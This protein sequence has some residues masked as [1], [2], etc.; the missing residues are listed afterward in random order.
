MTTN[1]ALKPG[2]LSQL[3]HSAG[4]FADASI[5]GPEIGTLV[6]I[7]D[8]A[9]N[10]PNRK[11]I[12]KQDP[13]CAA[14]LGKEAHKT[15]TDIRGG[16]TPRWDQELRFKVHD[17]PDYYQLKVSIFN[18][19]KKTDLIGE[20]WVDLKDI[21]K[22]GGGQN[23]RW[24][25][26]GC[27]GKYAGEIRIEL[28]YYDN[29]PKP[30]T[31]VRSGDLDVSPI[32]ADPT[33]GSA[34]RR[35]PVKRRPLP[36]DPVTG[37]IPSHVNP[38]PPLRTAPSTSH[39]AIPPQMQ[40]AVAQPHRVGP[41][42]QPS[43]RAE[44][45]QA[46]ALAQKQKVIRLQQQQQE[47]LERNQA[48]HQ[49]FQQ[50]LAKKEAAAAAATAAAVAAV[51]S[52]SPPSNQGYTR[53]QYGIPV[54]SDNPQVAEAPQEARRPNDSHGNIVDP[55]YP[56]HHDSFMGNYHEE[57]APHMPTQAYGQQQM[58]LDGKQSYG[59][60]QQMDDAP[61]P[62]PAHRSR[63]GSGTLQSQEASYRNVY[64]TVQPAKPNGMR[65][66]VLR[67]QAHRNPVV[68]H[69]SPEHGPFAQP[70]YHGAPHQQ[71]L[72]HRLSMQPTVEDV[73][74][75][76]NAASQ[77]IIRKSVGRPSQLGNSDPGHEPETAGQYQQNSVQVSD[78]SHQHHGGPKKNQ[79][80][81]HQLSQA[82]AHQYQP[83]PPAHSSASQ[84]SGH[85]SQ[86]LEQ[87]SHHRQVSRHDSSPD[88]NYQ[89]PPP[90]APQHQTMHSQHHPQ[91]HPVSQM[92]QP[93][94]PPLSTSLS[95]NN[96]GSQ[97]NDC[98]NHQIS[99]KFGHTVTQSPI[100]GEG[101]VSSPS[102]YGTSP[103][104]NSSPINESSDMAMTLV[105]RPVQD[106]LPGPSIPASLIPGVDP[107]IAQEISDLAHEKRQR[108]RGFSYPTSIKTFSYQPS[109]GQYQ[110]QPQ[111][112]LP[113]PQYQ[114]SN[115]RQSQ[116]QFQAHSQ[117]GRSMTNTEIVP[118]G[119]NGRGPSPRPYDPKDANPSTYLRHS[120]S[121]R[122]HT[123]Q[124]PSPDPYYAS[125][126]RD[127]T[128]Y[129]Q[130]NSAVFYDGASPHQP[131]PHS[132]QIV[133]HG[134][135]SP[136]SHQNF[137]KSQSPH[138]YSGRS[139]S[140]N[141]YSGGGQS[142]NPYSG[143]SPSPNPSTGRDPSPNPYYE[144]G[145]SPNPHTG[146]SPSP[147]P[148][149]QPQYTIRRK[150]VSPAP[151]T[152]QSRRSSAVPFNPASYDEYNTNALVERTSGNSN[153]KIIM[154]DGREVD[155]TDHL[156][157]ESWA[158][159]PDRPRDDNGRQQSPQPSGRSRP[160]GPSAYP[161]PS[162]RRQLKIAGH[163]PASQAQ[164]GYGGNDVP[165][166]NPYHPG[167]S[168]VRNRLQKKSN[169]PSGG[170]LNH[171]INPLGPANNSYQ[172]NFNPGQPTRA[173]TWDY[174]QE[175]NPPH[176]SSASRGAIQGVPIVP[177][178]VSTTSSAL[179]RVAPPR[180]GGPANPD[181]WAL[182][183]EMQRIDIGSGRSRRHGG[184]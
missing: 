153:D 144:R 105:T 113:P 63:G 159:E 45:Q 108:E 97:Y 145:C 44:Q 149:S 147:N 38:T 48:Q 39:M 165:Q 19:D 130:R 79:N 184:Y 96:Q 82:P 4:I 67:N 68:V 164:I 115:P 171:G 12:G 29:R 174:S 77:T 148:R 83:S 175:N 146:R 125:H 90:A 176:N 143:G 132:Q 93:H 9:K 92:E 71:A 86:P 131:S 114:Q 121:P 15:R 100:H 139:P 150:S 122:P 27:R 140:P 134:K 36:S 183:E 81:E 34:R 94:L 64:E 33:S 13:Y 24:Q 37:E 172:E 1:K 25:S 59:A 41:R 179:V 142:P 66:E 178:K 3:Q 7:V 110:Q 23:D 20:T 177:A 91:S 8:R 137:E 166:G 127:Q 133:H 54:H 99:D 49:K 40:D 17:S 163:T 138:P 124:E 75:S 106:K 31:A 123:A 76:P 58:L 160:E 50:A 168:Q 169:R 120:P 28:T 65:Q 101:H 107:I 161:G 2:T 162:G 180:G 136:S 46:A 51:V 80:E 42:P 156:P 155:P 95:H 118:Y 182:M 116:D 11:T 70:R 47:L 103:Q 104:P 154:Y 52:S 126:S 129:S 32:S 22:H 74:D 26:L 43:T 128:G 16:Q 21:I 117:R 84:F 170:H 6:L 119:Y 173:K 73:P 57:S 85:N 89:A 72:S 181:D 61:P 158:P 112:Q 18:D 56:K 69:E 78:Q 87:G 98:Q 14:R 35:S 102:P 157:I 30:V 167:S 151:P 88:T 152:S 55:Q 5:D 10:L 60:S 53:D 109:Q 141:P 135:R 62:P 111:G